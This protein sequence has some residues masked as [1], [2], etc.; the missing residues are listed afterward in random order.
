MN[1]P[2]TLIRKSQISALLSIKYKYESQVEPADSSRPE[3]EMYNLIS[4]I[5]LQLNYKTSCFH[6]K[7]ASIM[8]TL[9]CAGA[10][11][12]GW[13]GFW[14]SESIFGIGPHFVHLSKW[15]A[16]LLNSFSLDLRQAID[17]FCIGTIATLCNVLHTT[18]IDS[19]CTGAI[20]T[21]SNVLCTQL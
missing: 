20:A 4:K 12:L 18:A 16:W 8:Y 11:T 10:S 14:F 5:G 7:Y 19:F 15:P 2:K 6:S 9:T 3:A 13:N 21:L 17:S 1:T